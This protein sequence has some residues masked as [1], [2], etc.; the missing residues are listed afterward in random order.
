MTTKKPVVQAQW[1]PLFED[2][3]LILT[4]EGFEVIMLTPEGFYWTSSTSFK[5]IGLE[6]PIKDFR[7]W[8]HQKGIRQ[9]TVIATG[10]TGNI[11]LLL[12]LF[13]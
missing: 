13:K 3:L 1:H 4:T 9:M 5:V 10:E 6:E 2:F 7:F 12:C 11:H 8:P